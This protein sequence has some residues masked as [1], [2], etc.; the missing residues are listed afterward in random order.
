MSCRVHTNP[1]RALTSKVLKAS[2]LYLWPQLIRLDVMK[3]A[4]SLVTTVELVVELADGQKA[5]PSI[6]ISS[7][8]Q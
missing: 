4:G 8:Q 1:R 3:Y 2:A 7:E 5:F 6:I